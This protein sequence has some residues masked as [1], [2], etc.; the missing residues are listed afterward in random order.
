[1]GRACLHLVSV[2]TRAG[3]PVTLRPQSTL[4][5]EATDDDE[6]SVDDN[7]DDERVVVWQVEDRAHVQASVVIRGG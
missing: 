3:A 2:G 5:T 7:P 6:M 1:M 4:E